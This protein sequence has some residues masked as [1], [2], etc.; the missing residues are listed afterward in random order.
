MC[1]FFNIIIIFFFKETYRWWCHMNKQLCRTTGCYG[2]E[3]QSKNKSKVTFSKSCSA[4]FFSLVFFH[5]FPPISLFFSLVRCMRN[6]TKAGQWKSRSVWRGGEGWEK[7]NSESEGWGG[8]RGWRCR[9]VIQPAELKGELA[10]S[11][12]VISL[13]TEHNPILN[14][15]NTHIILL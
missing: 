7:G 15:K 5:S 14:N 9:H 12:I 4:L 13:I 10:K 8:E 3:S 2:S 6:L 1:L 11:C